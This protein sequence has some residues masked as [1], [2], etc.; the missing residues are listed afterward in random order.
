MWITGL[1][2]HIADLMESIQMETISK[3][4]ASTVNIPLERLSITPPVPKSVKIEVTSRCDLKCFFC[5]LTIKDRVKGNMDDKLMYKILDGVREAGVEEVGLFWIGEPFLNKSLAN[6]VAY[7]KKIGIN[8]VFVTTNG[9][10][11]NA[12]RLRP[13]F[14]A[15]LD[16][17]KFSMNATS[18]HT[19]QATTGVDGYDQV[20]A[21]IMTASQIRGDNPT[22]RIYASSVFDINKPEDYKKIDETIVPYVDEHYPLRLY[23]EFT[24]DS[25]SKE[26][27]HQHETNRTL[28]SM[29]PC[30]SLFT[31]PHI[32]YDGFISACFCDFDE[33]FFMADLKEVSFMEAWHSLKFQALRAAHL[34]KDVTGLPCI[35]CTAYKKG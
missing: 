25:D 35:N 19:F 1:S 2:H 15:G 20:I 32:S 31:V 22:P 13:V 10:L 17:I 34:K 33:A 8:Y 7:A 3:K 21:N 16:S 18:K 24:L 9:R 5:Q 26:V 27:V 6:Y 29:L 12:E 11:A 4:V 14:E 23:G 30:W 28:E